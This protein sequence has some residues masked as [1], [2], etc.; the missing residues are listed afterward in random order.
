MTPWKGARL[1]D[2][3]TKGDDITT[4]EASLEESLQLFPSEKNLTSVSVN[5]EEKTVRSTNDQSRLRHSAI[6]CYD[7]CLGNS[8]L[9][10]TA[11]K[12]MSISRQNL[13]R[14]L[15]NNVKCTTLLVLLFWCAVVIFVLHENVMF[16]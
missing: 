16:I 8:G 11:G 9:S 5:L 7:K 4:V 2:F 10:N 13:C 6:V 12:V 14:N 1:R 3:K 15:H